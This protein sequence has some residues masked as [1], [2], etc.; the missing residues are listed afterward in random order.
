MY[1]FLWVIIL[2]LIAVSIW[3]FMTYQRRYSEK[4]YRMSISL[5]LF[6]TLIILYTMVMIGFSV[7]Y[8]T[9]SFYTVT[10]VEIGQVPGPSKIEALIR[11]IYFSGVTMLTIGYGD[12]IP[13]G[14]GRGFAVIQA[15]IGYILPTCFV[16]KLVQTN[17]EKIKP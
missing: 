13:V 8:F 17:L 14:P 3:Q 2:T 5:E 15:L 16:M 10:L 12:I 6:Y 11:S 1:H 7:L 4:G 9:A